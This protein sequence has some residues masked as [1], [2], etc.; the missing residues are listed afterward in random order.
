VSFDPGQA[1]AGRLASA[2][3]R[4]NAQPMSRFIGYIVLVGA[5]CVGTVFH[6][7]VFPEV[8]EGAILLS[9]NS[10][11]IPSGPQVAQALGFIDYLLPPLF[12]VLGAISIR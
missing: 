12:L 1:G 7:R 4:M 8:I 6:A 2:F 9:G 3:D 10:N 5:S 11:V